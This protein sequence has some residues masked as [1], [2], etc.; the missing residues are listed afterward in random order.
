MFAC[1]CAV[2]GGVIVAL[3]LCIRLTSKGV[4]RSGIADQ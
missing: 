1:M 2:V 3:M 4:V